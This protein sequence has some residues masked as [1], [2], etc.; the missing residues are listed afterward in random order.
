MYH[1]T[2]ILLFAI[3]A[4]LG[5]LGALMFLETRKAR[6]DKGDKKG[7]IVGSIFLFTVAIILI[8]GG[9]SVWLSSKK[10][11]NLIDNAAQQV[12]KAVTQEGA[13][14]VKTQEQ[15]QQTQVQLQA[16]QNTK[17]QEA[18]KAVKSFAQAQK[19]FNSV[20]TSYQSEIKDIS[21]GNI[22]AAG[23]ADLD[24]LSLQ[25]LDLFRNVQNMDIA[26]Q[27]TYQKQVMVTAVL[28]LQGSMDDLK[29]FMDD[30]KINKFTEAQDFLHKAVE[31]NKLV[32]VGVSKQ[33]L[34]DGYNPPQGKES[35]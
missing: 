19:M 24:R 30:K 26:K 20:L 33:A 10:N 25:A 1:I 27:Y 17:K 11:Q 21:N 14:P 4:F 28:Y 16:Q 8:S 32:T 7:N 35:Q 29:S 15:P 5:L 22:N 6:M 18:E 3:G 34:I 12:P 31:A 9:V 13:S 23:Y 2:P